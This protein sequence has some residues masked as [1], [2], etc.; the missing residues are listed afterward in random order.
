[1]KWVSPFQETTISFF[2]DVVIGACFMGIESRMIDVIVFPTR[3]A[4]TYRYDAIE[5]GWLDEM[6]G[7]IVAMALSMGELN[8]PFF[9]SF[10]RPSFFQGHGIQPEYEM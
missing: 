5:L 7:M 4:E 10:L 9:F 6:P 8:W 2:S 3:H 1:M